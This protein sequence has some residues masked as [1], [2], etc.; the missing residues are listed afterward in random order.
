MSAV[1]QNVL[2]KSHL[3][4]DGAVLKVFPDLSQNQSRPDDKSHR[5]APSG[6]QV[7][8]DIGKCKTN[9]WDGRTIEVTGLKPD[10]TGDSILLLFESKLP[11]DE[12]AFQRIQRHSVRCVIYI[13]FETADG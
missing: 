11:D 2:D 7:E 6:R 12:V 5:Q 8:P 4:L 1:A 3:Q 9:M 10:T 13:T